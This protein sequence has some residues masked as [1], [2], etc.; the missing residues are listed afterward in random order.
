[1]PTAL[2][3]TGLAWIPPP[4]RPIGGAAT[5]PNPT[6]RGRPGTKRR[7]ATD[8]KGIPLT[9]LLTGANVHDSVPF[10]ELIDAISFS[11]IN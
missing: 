6:D 1:M 5:G 10:E 2:T 4:S 9:F 11:E 7:L 8:A 3:G